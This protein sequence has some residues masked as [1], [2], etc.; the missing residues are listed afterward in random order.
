MKK[1]L[2]CTCLVGLSA[3]NAEALTILNN[4]PDLPAGIIVR[5]N[6]QQIVDHVNLPYKATHIVNL[7]TY[8]PTTYLVA[9]IDLRHGDANYQQ[10]NCRLP[11][12]PKH[13]LAKWDTKTIKFGIT[14]E[15]GEYY[16]AV[17]D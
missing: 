14:E 5:L 17:L 8:P 11:I 16:C 13:T 9:I 2:L 3:A 12:N 15:T 1:L 7:V 10:V 6:G 4:I